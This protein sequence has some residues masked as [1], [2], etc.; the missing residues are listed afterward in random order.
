MDMCTRSIR[1]FTTVTGGFVAT[2]DPTA[3]P[4]KLGTVRNVDDRARAEAI[5][6]LW[7]AHA[8]VVYAYALRRAP[9][10]A[11]DV[12]VLTFTV[13]WRKLEHLP[14]GI[15]ARWWLLRVARR[16]VA[17]VWRAERRR[18]ALHVSLASVPP[19][20][21]EALG[22]ESLAA[23][24]VRLTPAHR[25]VLLLSAWE[26]LAAPEIAAVLGISLAAAE[27]R[28]QRAKKRFAELFAPMSGSPALVGIAMLHGASRAA[29]SD[30]MEGGAGHVR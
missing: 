5:R 2:L 13:A 23:V 6:A 8:D 14:D 18:R 3:P 10:Y 16:Q 29:S 12:R 7:D 17:H 11:D 27:K 26:G 4:H 24:L 20:S 25:E 15:E 22:D 30:S 9:S 21:A 1:A 19:P 28:L